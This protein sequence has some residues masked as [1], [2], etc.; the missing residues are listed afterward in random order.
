MAVGTPV[1]AGRAG[2][3]PEITGGAATLVDPLDVADIADGI[4]SA[5][6]SD[7]SRREAGRERAGLFTWQKTAS[8]TAAV[9][10]ELA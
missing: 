4:E 6:G 1:V 9:Y 8:A 5:I 10:R 7:D 2:A 3:L